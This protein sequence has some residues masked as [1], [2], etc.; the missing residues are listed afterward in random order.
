MTTKSANM[1]EDRVFTEPAGLVLQ[2]YSETIVRVAMILVF[3]SFGF[4]KFSAYEANAIAGLALNSP[5]LAGLHSAFGVQG[6]S[7]LIGVTELAAAL[8]LAAG[9]FAP[10]LGIVGALISVGNYLTTLSFLITT[11]GVTEASAGGFPYLS[12]MPGQFLVKDVV[13]LAVSLWL[14]ATS[15]KES[16]I[17]LL[18]I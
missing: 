1:N 13:L 12:V 17:E 15:L 2:R 6:L 4:H 11:P 3:L 18:D 10:R 16:E 7:N 14:L 9:F 5:L 8:L